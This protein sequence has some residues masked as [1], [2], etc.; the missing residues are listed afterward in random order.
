MNTICFLIATEEL[1]QEIESTLGKLPP[2]NKTEQ[3]SV[4]VEILD[5]PHVVDQ[6]YHLIEEG[7]QVIIT[8]TGVYNL[9]L[10]VIKEVPILCLHY[11]TNDF[12]YTLRK[13]TSFKKIHVFLNQAML[14]N[15]SKSPI[16]L[17]EKITLHHYDYDLPVDVIAGGVNSIPYSD[18]TAVISCMLLPQFVNT[19]LPMFPIIPS[20]SAIISAYQYARDTI[21][22]SR[23]EKRYISLFSSILTNVDDG[24]IIYDKDG[25]VTHYNKIA[26]HFLNFTYN[27][28][29][30]QSIFP[31][32]EEAKLKPPFFK[33]KIL[34]CPPF[35]LLANTKPFTLNNKTFYMLNIRDVT[36]LQRLEN[37]VRLKLSKTGLRAE[38]TFDDILTLDPTMRQCIDMAK[39]M[40]RYDSSPPPILIQGE[41]GTGKELFAQS[42]HNAS[43][44]RSG[45]FVAV[46][47]AALPPDLL[48]SE[49]FGYVGGAFTDARK[50]GKAGLFE[51]AHNGTIFLDEINS[52]PTD[53][54]AKLLRVLETKQ[55]MR[56]GSDYVLPLDIRIISSSNGKIT[57]MVK[58]GEFRRDLY[59]RLNPFTIIL[60]SLNERPSDIFYLFSIFLTKITRH[61][62]SI[63]T[64]LRPILE[65][66][67]WWGNIRELYSAALRYHLY[68]DL[69]DPTYSYLF[70]E[71]TAKREEQPVSIDG[72]KL[73]LTDMQDVLEE[74]LISYFLQQGCTK[75]Q[76]AG[77]LGMSRQGLFKKLKKLDEKNK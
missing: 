76:A 35:T 11:S 74:S 55:V 20:D 68:S 42:I 56:I 54:Q 14:L 73:N 66:H 61:P 18:D 9:L 5:F 31:D 62:V 39:K 71:D 25:N 27:P 15:I 12:I 2:L 19:D 17:Q 41:S 24:I 48:E 34:H 33:E 51:L 44:R 23:R 75:T 7:A 77:I 6:A 69:H 43:P 52:M 32:L 29:S 13:A 28:G 57:D 26:Y 63:P 8:N 30:I 36:E 22:A 37:D 38:H 45:P 64:A 72:L 70:D 1:K 49:L 21:I 67:H 65:R 53:L 10:K 4:H 60:P 50:Q 59:F 40:A 3:I 58:K 47:C 46:N 16:E